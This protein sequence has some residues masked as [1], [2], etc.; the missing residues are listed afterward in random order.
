MNRRPLAFLTNP[1]SGGQAGRALH[2][3]LAARFPGRV[4]AI[5]TTDAQALCRTCADDGAA[6]IACGGDG[7]ASHALDSSW[8][9][10]G[11]V[12]IGIIPLGTGNDLAR[13]LGWG[14]SAPAGAAL[15]R[16]LNRLAAA[17]ARRIDRWE[18]KGPG[19]ERPWFNYWSTGVDAAIALRFHLLRARKPWLFRHRLLNM[20][21][22]GAL[23]L[24]DALTHLQ[25][26]VRCDTAAVPERAGALVIANI[27]RWAG[28]VHLPKRIAD[29]DGLADGLAIAA[30]PGLALTALGWKAPQHL[31]ATATW[32]IT[33]DRE[34]VMHCDGEP[35]LAV[36]GTWT[37]RHGG[38][39]PVL[40]A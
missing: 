20:G 16:H 4:H 31:A 12:P 25:G 9:T 22:Y 13:H 40:C 30:G 37:S 26:T 36:A 11:T 34:L 23:G 1:T 28:G 33:T 14:G 8:R 2:A 5:R 32:T 39:V 27:G 35:F 21:I 3:L 17:A 18:L 6:L 7:T 38:Q 19:V 29:D 15:D 24:A 10:G